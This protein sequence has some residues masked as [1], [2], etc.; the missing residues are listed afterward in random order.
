MNSEIHG[1][2]G[3]DRIR[4]SPTL[5]GNLAFLPGSAAYGSIHYSKRSKNSSVLTA[6][7]FSFRLP[8]LSIPDI[9]SIFS[10]ELF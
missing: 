8:F 3:T 9:Q 2:F 7:E 4:V 1:W 6:L 10:G 5:R